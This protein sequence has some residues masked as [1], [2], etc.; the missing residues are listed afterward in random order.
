MLPT[1]DLRLRGDDMCWTP[2]FNGVT[3]CILP[4]PLDSGEILGYNRGW[5]RALYDEVC[6][7]RMNATIEDELSN[8]YLTEVRE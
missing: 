8:S 7:K 6:I 4:F 5:V 1:M 3:L 2:F